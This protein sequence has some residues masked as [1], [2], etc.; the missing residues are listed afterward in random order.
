MEDD[1]I[2]DILIAYSI[3]GDG[4]LGRLRSLAERTKALS[5]VADNDV[6]V[7]G[8]GKAFETVSRPLTVLVECGTGGRRCGV[9]T[10]ERAIALARRISALPGIGFGG[11]MT[12]P[13]TG[14]QRDVLGFMKRAKA[15]VD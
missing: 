13:A 6:V 2:D 9:R 5:V 7:E 11:F 8:L 10:S 15:G 4:K 12:C 14:G 3:L 1:G